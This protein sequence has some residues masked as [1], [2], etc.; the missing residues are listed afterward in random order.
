MAGTFKKGK[1]S[2]LVVVKESSSLVGEKEEEK[3]GKEKTTFEVTL[4]NASDKIAFFIFP[5]IILG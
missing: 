3:K 5:L 2:S 1:R 4:N